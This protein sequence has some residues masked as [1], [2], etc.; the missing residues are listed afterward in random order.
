MSGRAGNASAHGPE[1][2][3]PVQLLATAL[4]PTC[5]ASW[6]GQERGPRLSSH[7]QRNR[8][9]GGGVQPESSDSGQPVI[10]GCLAKPLRLQS[11]GRW[12]AGGGPQKLC[13]L[14]PK[15]CGGGRAEN[16][17]GKLPAPLTLSVKGLKGSGGTEHSALTVAGRGQAVQ[18]QASGRGVGSQGPGHG[19]PGFR[20]GAGCHTHCVAS[21]KLF[22]PS[23]PLKTSS[24]KVGV[25][26]AP[27]E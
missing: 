6:K 13:S 24:E 15:Q 16:N 14:D 7:S 22:N 5:G 12:L 9:P 21:S 23:A 17:I 3:P 1:P 2:A 10:T 26:P 27:R 18:G 25:T 11:P 20:S 4:S 19:Q 8:V